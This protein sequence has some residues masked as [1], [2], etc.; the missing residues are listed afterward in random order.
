MQFWNFLLIIADFAMFRIPYTTIFTEYCASENPQVLLKTIVFTYFWAT[1][2]S[3]LF[4]VLFCVLRVAILYS[5]SENVTE[6]LIKI[7]PPVIIT[8][9]LLCALPHYSGAGYCTQLA[10]PYDFGAI[11]IISEYH[12]SNFYVMFF[13]FCMY[14]SVTVIITILTTMML[15]KIRRNKSIGNARSSQQNAKVE[16]TLTETMI[17][18]L[19]P[20]IFS[21]LIMIG[22]ISRNPTFSYILLAR[23]VFLDA[24]VH[25]ATCYFYWTHPIFKKMQPQLSVSIIHNSNP[26]VKKI[27]PQGF[28]KMSTATPLS[29][30]SIMDVP[31]F[32]NYDFH[33]NWIFLYV[34][35]M[36]CYSI[37]PILIFLRIA[38][39]FLFDIEKIKNHSLRSE[40]IYSFLLMQ[41][42]NILFVVADFALFRIPSTSVLTSYCAAQN[43]QLL[44]KTIVFMYFWTIYCNQLFTVLF[45]GLRVFILYSASN[46]TT[47]R[48]IKVLPPLIIIFGLLAAFPHYS[49]DGFCLYLMEPFIFGSIIITSKFH[50]SSSYAI[51]FNLFLVAITISILT[52]LMLIKVKKKKSISTSRSSNQTR[53][54]ERTLTGTMTILLFPLI[55]SMLI[56]TAEIFTIPSFHFILLIRPLFLVA[57]VHFATC[58]F[59]WTHPVFK[60]QKSTVPS[61]SRNFSSPTLKIVK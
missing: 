40:I 57:R 55:A 23:P 14:L 27:S 4:T 26:N 44:L 18:M 53:K 56:A 61:V 59:Y 2:A 9:G 46:R 7:C 1:Y 10:K 58:Y 13:N 20:L 54:V 16:K 43:P 29:S 41:F 5:I 35:V 6:K 49:Q 36:V 45:C 32:V 17:I 24:R 33:F 3:Q 12:V 28:S 21:M 22:E 51:P 48:M 52:I 30:R 11:L 39:L 37:P 50:A 47:G 25:L 34:I 60:H 15:L 38:Y 19:I 31:E 8:F 42:F